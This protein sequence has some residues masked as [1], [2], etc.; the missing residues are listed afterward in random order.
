[1]SANPNDTSK[2]RFYAPML[3][4]D[5]DDL[6]P[7][8][9]YLLGFYRKWIGLH[10]EPCKL[11]LKAIGTIIKWDERKVRR[12]RNELILKNVIRVKTDIGRPTYVFLIDRRKENNERYQDQPLQKNDT[13]QSDVGD[14]YQKSVGDSPQKSVGVQAET[15]A[16]EEYKEEERI[17]TYAAGAAT[18][19]HVDDPDN[20]VSVDTQ[21]GSINDGALV[22]THEET[23]TPIAPAP[24]PSVIKV[25]KHNTTEI[26]PR[27]PLFDSIACLQFGI[28]DTSKMP[29]DKRGRASIGALVGKIKKVIVD[30]YMAMKRV[31]ALTPDE[32][33]YLAAQHGKFMVWWQTVKYPPKPGYKPL[34]LRSADKFDVYWNEFRDYVRAQSA[35]AKQQR[36]QHDPDCR[37]CGGYGTVYYM[38]PRHDPTNTRMRKLGEQVPAGW[39][40]TSEDCD[41]EVTS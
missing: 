18:G 10:G 33:E 41:C 22:E 3:H 32:F 37:K 7:D 39:Y 12:V 31:T 30:Q 27:D 20:M 2:L 15:Q 29:T 23:P 4:I 35:I 25:N 9:Y 34:E 13:S 16:E 24:P 38:A 19:D 14:G 8:Q 11:S 21:P 26:R 28:A 1:M 6:N 40:E 36:K 5:L 17:N